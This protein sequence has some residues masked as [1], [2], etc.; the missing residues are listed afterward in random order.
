MYVTKESDFIQDSIKFIDGLKVRYPKNSYESHFNS[1]VSIISTI[2]EFDK[3]YQILAP[4][5]TGLAI[6]MVMIEII[7]QYH[8]Q[9]IK[10]S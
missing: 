3:E 5:N 1:T 10:E 6:V 9:I 8:L 4:I 7:I 2:K